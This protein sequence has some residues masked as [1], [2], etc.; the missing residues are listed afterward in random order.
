LFISPYDPDPLKDSHSL[1]WDLGMAE[2]QRKAL[3][4][5]FNRVAQRYEPDAYVAV[6]AC[7]D[8]TT[9]AAAISLVAEAAGFVDED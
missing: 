6:G 8:L 5:P 2:Y 3:Q 4:A 7:A 9:V 1:R